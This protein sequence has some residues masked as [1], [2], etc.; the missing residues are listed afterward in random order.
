VRQLR[1]N[2]ALLAFAVAPL[3]FD[4]CINLVTG[5]SF[6]RA[7]E[8]SNAWVFPFL[9]ASGSALFIYNLREARS[10]QQQLSSVPR[11]RMSRVDKVIN[12]RALTSSSATSSLDDQFDEPTDQPAP[13]VP[14]ATVGGLIADLWARP[15][16][17]IRPAA[18]RAAWQLAALINSDNVR[19]AMRR[20][21]LTDDQLSQPR[22]KW[23]IRPDEVSTGRHDSLNMIQGRIGYLISPGI[24]AGDAAQ[25]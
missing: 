25:A 9:I 22:L 24:P 14:P 10:R 7:L 21:D 13:D 6:A 15:G 4:V 23:L 12:R 1:I 8:G 20:V 19:A 11:E 17:D 5:G 18:Y 3:V 2:T 16:G